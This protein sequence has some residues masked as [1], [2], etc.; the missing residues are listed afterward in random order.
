L[1]WVRKSS[2]IYIRCSQAI[3]TPSFLFIFLG[4]KWFDVFACDKYMKKL[5]I[6]KTLGDNLKWADDSG[7]G[8]LKN[9]DSHP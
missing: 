3:K 8:Y 9:A 1:V 4:K 2:L 6:I 5:G 7:G